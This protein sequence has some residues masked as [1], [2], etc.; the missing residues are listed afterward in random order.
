MAIF[1]LHQAE[2]EGRIKVRSRSP[3]RKDPVQRSVGQDGDDAER[4]PDRRRQLAQ[5][6]PDQCAD[7]DRHPNYP[8]PTLESPRLDIARPISSAIDGLRAESARTPAE[9]RIGPRQVELGTQQMMQR[10]E[11][12]PAYQHKWRAQPGPAELKRRL[13][14]RVPAHSNPDGSLLGRLTRN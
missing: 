1:E 12:Q 4:I 8:L 5:P 9:R 3:G 14:R 10:A 13:R 6:L 7:A 11:A 2:R